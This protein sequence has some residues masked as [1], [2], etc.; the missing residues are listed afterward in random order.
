MEIS[1]SEIQKLKRIKQLVSEGKCRFKIRKDR[2]YFDDLL[3]LGIT[4]EQAWKIVLYL[5]PN[6]FFRD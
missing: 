2:N 5:K 4:E 3:N 6:A 1:N